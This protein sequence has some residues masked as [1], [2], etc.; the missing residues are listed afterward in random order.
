MTTQTWIW[1]Y[2]IFKI[3]HS[4]EAC[5][6]GGKSCVWLAIQRWSLFVVSQHLRGRWLIAGRFEEAFVGLPSTYIKLQVWFIGFYEEQCSCNRPFSVH[7]NQYMVGRWVTHLWPMSG[8]LSE[9]FPSL[10]LSNWF[11][12]REISSNC[13]NPNLLS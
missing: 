6:P 10:E 7:I 8:I 12:L 11:W 3:W 13:E 5:L 1:C 2:S 9:K 4:D